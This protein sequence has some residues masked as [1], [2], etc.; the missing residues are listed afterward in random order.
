M[1]KPKSVAK[2]EQE[3]DEIIEKLKEE[4]NKIGDGEATPPTVA[5]NP[6][7]PNSINVP[8][9]P[10]KQ[11]E[12]E[13]K[14]KYEVLQGKYN[15]EVPRL[16]AEVRLLKTETDAYKV[17][18]GELQRQMEDVL[19]SSN[20]SSPSVADADIE[21]IKSI[22]EQYGSEFVG[23]LRNLF[24]KEFQNTLKPYNE[25]LA[26]IE[27]RQNR[28]AWDTYFNAI[29]SR[30]PNW[31][32]INRDPA[33]IEWLSNNRQQFSNKSYMDILRDSHAM[34]DTHAV[35]KI[36]ET[37]LTS[38]NTTPVDAATPSTPPNRGDLESMVSPGKSKTNTTPVR[39]ND[40]FV[41]VA[42]IE[43]FYDDLRRGKYAGKEIEARKLD[44][45]YTQA[46]ASGRVK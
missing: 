46:V 26:D 23:K 41:S 20:P 37:Y 1:A 43:Q 11:S 32:S 13:W 3:V 5:E 15:A 16:N 6:I 8:T 39:Q 33:F 14:H 19:K 27:A 28:S 12:D 18:M 40:E 36:F 22:E 30:I 44:E 21:S 2:H 35:V 4:Q 31:Q 42:K 34:A 38:I 45:F 25:K 24:N 17:H 9:P 10:A 29:S 7:P